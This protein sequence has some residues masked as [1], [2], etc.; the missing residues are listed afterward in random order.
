MYTHPRLSSTWIAFLF[1]CIVGCSPKNAIFLD[2]NFQLTN[3][4]KITVLPVVDVRVDTSIAVNMEKQI[5][6]KVMYLLKAKGYRTTLSDSLGDVGLITEDILKSSKPQFIRRLGPPQDRWIMVLML[7]DVAQEIKI[8]SNPTGIA[9][10]AGFLFDKEK[11]V[12]TWRDKGISKVS[13]VVG[14]LFP[15]AW[16]MVWGM[17]EQAI[18]VA[19]DNLMSSFP[20]NEAPDSKEVRPRFPR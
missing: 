14:G 11:G 5:R 1:V 3:I 20:E 4:N 9:E 10:V 17:D 18:S 15:I 6:E 2:P 8:T 7:I 16:A 13:D 12:I 19:M